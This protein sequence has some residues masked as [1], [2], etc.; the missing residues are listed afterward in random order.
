[1]K[2]KFKLSNETTEG[3]HR[4]PL[5]NELIGL[6]DKPL[7]THYPDRKATNLRNSNWLQQLDGDDF[8]A[9]K[10]LNHNIMK[11]QEKT[12]LLKQYA[13]STGAPLQEVRA[14]H[15]Q[16]T[17]P[18]YFNMSAGESRSHHD[19]SSISSIEKMEEEYFPTETLF[20]PEVDTRRE[21]YHYQVP[22]TTRSKTYNKAGKKKGYLG[23]V[24]PR[25][26][27]F[28][29]KM[30]EEVAEEHD[31]EFDDVMHEA[32]Q[33]EEKEKSF[34]DQVASFFFGETMTDIDHHM[35]Q[36]SRKTKEPA[37]PVREERASAST[38][39]AIY[40][41]PVAAR[42]KAKAKAENPKDDNPESDHEPKGPPGRPK[43]SKKKE[44]K[45]KKEPA[46]TKRPEVVHGTQIFFRDTFEEWM[47]E[48]KGNL[49]DQIDRRK[50]IRDK[51]KVKTLANMTKGK[52]VNLIM[53]ADK[54]K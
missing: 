19:A 46:A 20:G 27:M 26:E 28:N 48:P 7:I 21:Q 14:M 17:Q 39:V 18:E 6:L 3:L 5:Y 42:P 10:Q 25:G 37:S 30:E 51:Y 53:E 23:K 52:L 16:T 32:E 45:V 49:L 33:K 11:D 34:V 38:G 40:E 15:T 22:T 36:H 29:E 1:M 8:Q 13:Q 44:P 50:N 2:H 12:I 54:N 4:R 24:N 43:G 9:I 35:P 47:K 41:S 31:A